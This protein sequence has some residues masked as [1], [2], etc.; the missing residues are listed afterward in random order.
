MSF[1]KTGFLKDFS[2]NH[3][4]RVEILVILT[5]ILFVLYIFHSLN[6]FKKQ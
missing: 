6:L 2:L 4:H 5:I 3:I 1:L